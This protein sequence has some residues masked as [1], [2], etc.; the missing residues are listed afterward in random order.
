[1]VKVTVAPFDG[2]FEKLNEFLTGV[3][4]KFRLEG[5]MDI[6]TQ[7]AVILSLCQSSTAGEWAASKLK[8]YTTGMWPTTEAAFTDVLKK[9]FQPA[10]PESVAIA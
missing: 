5:I 7:V 3:T 4:L 10:D 9:K 8:K 1:M 6:A 2:S